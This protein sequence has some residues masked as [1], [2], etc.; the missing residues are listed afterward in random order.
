[1]TTTGAAKYHDL[2]REVPFPILIVEEAAEVFEGHI[3]T[4]LSEHTEHIGLIGDHQQLKPNPANYVLET[5]YNLNMSL[6]ER[7]VVNDFDFTSL[8]IQRRMRPEISAIIRLLYPHLED[9]QKVKEYPHVRGIDK[10]VFFLDHDKLE[11]TD[12]GLLSKKNEY[13][14]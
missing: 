3:I 9:A 12:E 7:L 4:A 14:A 13:E 8:T 10:D 5:K 11:Q 6:F 2:L 1:M